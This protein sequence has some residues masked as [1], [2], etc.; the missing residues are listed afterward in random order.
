MRKEG[1][2]GWPKRA[3]PSIKRLIQARNDLAPLEKEY[4]G[5]LESVFIGGSVAKTTA[6]D[7]ESTGK[8]AGRG[9]DIDVVITHL[10]KYHDYVR[11]N[12][13]SEVVTNALKGVNSP[14]EVRLAPWE[15]EVLVPASDLGDWD[16]TRPFNM[17]SLYSTRINGFMQ[18][19][20][21]NCVVKPRKN[22]G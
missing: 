8:G 16:P 21:N 15:G 2:S 22:R 20:P 17:P 18:L 6:R 7:G 11:L 12:E 1:L 10:E 5:I 13:V 3:Q 9:S 4:P 19:R 14:Y